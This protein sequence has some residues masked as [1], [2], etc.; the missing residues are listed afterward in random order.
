LL[1]GAVLAGSDLPRE[2]IVYTTVRPAN[3]ELYLFSPGSSAKQITNDLALDYDPT[4]SWLVTI[5][6]KKIRKWKSRE[7]DS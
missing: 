7:V 1:F 6:L 3:W 4:F 5:K 2:R